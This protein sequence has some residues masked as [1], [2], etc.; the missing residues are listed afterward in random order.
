MTSLRGGSGR[1]PA[2][3]TKKTVPKLK[4]DAFYNARRYLHERSSFEEIFQALDRIL[5]TL[6]EAGKMPKDSSGSKGGSSPTATGLQ[7]LSIGGTNAEFDVRLATVLCTRRKHVIFTVA[8]TS[9]AYRRHVEEIMQ[10]DIVQDLLNSRRLQWRDESS[11]R[12]RVS[13]LSDLVIFNQC[14]Q[15]VATSSPPPEKIV[16]ET[17]LNTCSPDGNIVILQQGENSG[18]LHVRK[19]LDFLFPP[20]LG[21]TMLTDEEVAGSL[22]EEI[23]LRGEKILIETSQID[24]LVDVT[25]CIQRTRDGL[26]IV[27]AAFAGEISH[28]GEQMETTIEVM[29]ECCVSK[30]GDDG[31]YFEAP[32]GLIV[33]RRD[34]EQFEQQ[35]K[36][37]A[38]S[39]VAEFAEGSGGEGNQ[40]WVN[41]GLEEWHRRRAEWT[42]PKGRPRDPPKPIPYE[43]VIE[44]LA[45]LQS[46][47]ELPGWIRLPDLIDLYVEIWD[48]DY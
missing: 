6:C 45:T 22:S 9:E 3:R 26:Q 13:R 27:N 19:R 8:E 32:V 44:G 46:K 17:L 38:A 20:S 31:D 39:K 48:M 28:D 16:L 10:N 23:D 37:S 30:K 15:L 1:S 41:R 36:M 29:E 47:F 33:V 12:P 7:V 18:F 24:T 34:L 2:R 21:R 43:S 40:L 14:L 42:T 11:R 25:D 35:L 4:P 5:P